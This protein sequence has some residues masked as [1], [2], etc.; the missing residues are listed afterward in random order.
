MPATEMPDSHITMVELGGAS[1][2]SLLVRRAFDMAMEEQSRL[3]APLFDVR[4]FSGRKFRMFLHNLCSIVPQPRYLEIGVFCGGSFIPAI[5]DNDVTATALDNW[6]WEGANLTLF[7]E[8]LAKF[9]GRANVN[10]LEADFKTTGFTKIG[11][12]NI[13]FY[14]GSHNE[15]DQR[16][17][18]KLPVPAMDH[19]YIVIV[20]DWNWDHVRR[21]TFR[22]LREG[23]RSHPPA[24]HA[25]AI[26]GI[27]GSVRLARAAATRE[28][29]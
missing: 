1:Q 11:S 13:M 24:F 4:G 27:K 7:K 19:D 17:G 22:G 15:N 21:G 26:A 16:D 28:Q 3:Q 2:L 9:G 29:A 6:S 8:Y 23:N 20:D 14:D 18:V 5:Y 10:I 12:Y 25:A